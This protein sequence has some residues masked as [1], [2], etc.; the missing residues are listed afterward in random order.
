MN[1]HYLSLSDVLKVGLTFDET[2]T[3]VE[4]SLR[5]HGEKQVENPP[6]VPIHPLPDAFINA[7]P[8]FLPR[9][10]ACGMKWVSG[11]PTNVHVLNKAASV[12]QGHSIL[13]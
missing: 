1:I 7:M 9:K 12:A 8:A 11:F 2:I 13:Q 6:K 4:Q 3:I 10:N 5:E